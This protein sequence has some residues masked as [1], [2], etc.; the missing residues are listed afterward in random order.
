MIHRHRGNRRD[1]RQRKIDRKERIIK[2][3]NDFYFYKDQPGRLNKAKI[4]CSCPMCSTKTNTKASKSCGPV[5]VHTYEGSRGTVQIVKGSRMS[6]T[7]HRNGKKNYKPSD[8]RR[9]RKT[10]S[11]ILETFEPTLCGLI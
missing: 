1:M 7:N 3:Q 10:D 6:V 9:I 5:S 4:H 8:L 11:M 2:E